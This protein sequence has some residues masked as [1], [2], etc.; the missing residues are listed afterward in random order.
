MAIQGE[1]IRILNDVEPRGDG[2]YVLYLLQ[3]ANRATFNPALELAIE[4]AKATRAAA[5]APIGV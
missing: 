3:Q 2:A 4:E 1:R 5:A